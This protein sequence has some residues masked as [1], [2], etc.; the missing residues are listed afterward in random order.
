MPGKVKGLYMWCLKVTSGYKGLEVR[1]L[2]T[3][4]KN[5]LAFCAMLS[6]F[7][8]D[9]IDY[10][11]LNPDEVYKNN[12]LAFT[13]AEREFGIIKMLDPEDMVRME[14]PDRLSVATYLAQYYD[15]FRDKPMLDPPEAPEGYLERIQNKHKTVECEKATV[16]NDLPNFETVYE[17]ETIES[18]NKDSKLLEEDEM[19]KADDEFEALFNDNVKVLTDTDPKNFTDLFEEEIEDIKASKKGAVMQAILSAGIAAVA[20]TAVGDDC[21]KD[22]NESISENLTVLNGSN[23]GDLNANLSKE[24]DFKIGT[25]SLLEQEDDS[26]E[27]DKF[28]TDSGFGT[29][30]GENVN[31][32]YPDYQSEIHHLETEKT[33]EVLNAELNKV[34]IESIEVNVVN[35]NVNEPS[36]T[37]F[38]ERN[39]KLSSRSSSSSSSSESSDSESS[40]SESAP[41]PVDFESMADK[42]VQ[43]VFKDV[44][45]NPELMAEIQK[46]IPALIKEVEISIK[47][48]Q[49]ETQNM[50]PDNQIQTGLIS[51]EN[52][53]FVGQDFNIPDDDTEETH[54]TDSVD[55]IEKYQIALEE[56]EKAESDNESSSSK[57][58]TSSEESRA[59]SGDGSPSLEIEDAVLNEPTDYAIEEELVDGN[60]ANIQKILD[61]TN[62][63]DIP[64]EQGPD[65]GQ[66]S[67]PVAQVEIGVNIRETSDDIDDNHTTTSTSSEDNVNVVTTYDGKSPKHA[68]ESNLHKSSSENSEHE[69]ESTEQVKNDETEIKLTIDLTEHAPEVTGSDSISRRKILS[70]SSSSDSEN[71]ESK[72]SGYPYVDDEGHKHFNSENKSKE[73]DSSKENEAESVAFKFIE[74]RKRSSSSTSSSSNSESSGEDDPNVD[75]NHVTNDVKDLVKDTID[76]PK[77][78]DNETTGRIKISSDSECENVYEIPRADKD[79]EIYDNKDKN[80]A[81][82]STEIYLKDDISKTIASRKISSSSESDSHNS[83]HENVKKEETF[84]KIPDKIMSDSNFNSKH[85][86]HGQADENKYEQSLNDIDP[87]ID[88]DVSSKK[89]I[90]SFASESDIDYTTNLHYK[91]PTLYKLQSLSSAS[92]VEQQE[93]GPTFKAETSSSSSEDEE[94][95]ALPSAGPPE[96][97]KVKIISSDSESDTTDS[98]HEPEEGTGKEVDILIPSCDNETNDKAETTCVTIN[99]IDRIAGAQKEDTIPDISCS[100]QAQEALTSSSPAFSDHQVTLEASGNLAHESASMTLVADKTHEETYS[101]LIL[102]TPYDKETSS[103]SSSDSEDNKISNLKSPIKDETTSRLTNIEDTA[104]SFDPIS[105]EII[106]SQHM[107]LKLNFDIVDDHNRT[108]SKSVDMIIKAS[109]EEQSVK[110][111]SDTSSSSSSTSESESSESDSESK[112]LNSHSRVLDEKEPEYEKLR[113]QGMAGD[114]ANVS[115]EINTKCPEKYSELDEI[116]AP[117]QSATKELKVDI[118]S[119]VDMENTYVSEFSLPSIQTQISPKGHDEVDQ[120]VSKPAVTADIR[121]DWSNKAREISLEEPVK[122]PGPFA[123]VDKDVMKKAAIMSRKMAE[124]VTA[125]LEDQNR[126]ADIEKYKDDEEQMVTPPSTP[127]ESD[128]E[129]ARAKRMAIFKQLQYSTRPTKK[130]IED[131]DEPSESSSGCESP[132]DFKKTMFLWN[133][134]SSTNVKPDQSLIANKSRKISSPFLSGKPVSPT[135]EHMR[136]LH[137][138][139]PKDSTP[140]S[141]ADY[142]RRLSQSS[143]ADENLLTSPVD[144][145]KPAKTYHVKTEP[146]HLTV[147]TKVYPRNQQNLNKTPFTG[148]V[149]LPKSGHI[150]KNE[151]DVKPSSIFA[152]QSISR[153]NSQNQKPPLE[154]IGVRPMS[155]DLKNVTNITSDDSKP[156]N[157]V[158]RRSPRS[159]LKQGKL[160]VEVKPLEAKPLVETG[161]SNDDENCPIDIKRSDSLKDKVKVE[162]IALD[163]RLSQSDEERQEEENKT[164]LKR[165]ESLKTKREDSPRRSL[166]LSSPT[167]PEATIKDGDRVRNIWQSTCTKPPS[168]KIKRKDSFEVKVR[169][170]SLRKSRE[171]KEIEK[172]KRNSTRS[173]SPASRS[174]TPTK[175]LPK[176][177]ITVKPVSAQSSQDEN[178]LE[179]PREPKEIVVVEGKP[180]L[181][182]DDKRVV[183]RRPSNRRSILAVVNQMAG[184]KLKDKDD[185]EAQL[186]SK[187]VNDDQITAIPLNEHKQSASTS[188]EN[189][190]VSDTLSDMSVKKQMSLDSVSPENPVKSSYKH[191][192]EEAIKKCNSIFGLVKSHI[193]ASSKGTNVVPEKVVL[194]SNSVG[195]SERKELNADSKESSE[196]D[197]NSSDSSSSSCKKTKKTGIK[198]SLPTINAEVGRSG[199]VSD[200]D[201]F[202]DNEAVTGS[203]NQSGTS[204]PSLHSSVEI[205][206]TSLKDDLEGIIKD[207]EQ[208]MKSDSEH[209]HQ[210]T[211]MKLINNKKARQSDTTDSDEKQSTEDQKKSKKK[212]RRKNKKKK[213]PESSSSSSSSESSMHSDS[214]RGDDGNTKSKSSDTSSNDAAPDVSKDGSSNHQDMPERKISD[215]SDRSSKSCRPYPV[216]SGVKDDVH[217]I[218]V[219]ETAET[220]KVPKGSTEIMSSQAIEIPQKELIF[221]V[222]DIIP[223]V[224]DKETAY[225]ADQE[226]DSSDDDV[227]DYD[228]DVKLTTK[229]KVKASKSSSESSL[230][231]IEYPSSDNGRYVDS[232]APKDSHDAHVAHED[233]EDE[234]PITYKPEDEDFEANHEPAEIVVCVP[235]PVIHPEPASGRSRT[236]SS[237]SNHSD[238]MGCFEIPPSDI[239]F[240]DDNTLEASSSDK[241]ESPVGIHFS[242]EPLWSRN[243]DNQESS[244]DSESETH[245]EKSITLHENEL[246]VNEEK[247]LSV[248]ERASSSGTEN[249]DDDDDYVCVKSQPKENNEHSFSN[250]ITETV[251][252]CLV[253]NMHP[254]NELK[255]ADMRISDDNN[256]NQDMEYDYI[257]VKDT[258]YVN[259]DVEDTE[260]DNVDIQDTE[261]DNVDVKDTEDDNI[262]SQYSEEDELLKSVIEDSH[263]FKAPLLETFIKTSF[264]EDMDSDKTDTD[265]VLEDETNAEA[266]VIRE[267]ES[268]IHHGKGRTSSVSSS[269]SSSSDSSKGDNKTG[270]SGTTDSEDDLYSDS[271]RDVSCDSKMYILPECTMITCEDV[272]QKDLDIMFK[273]LDYANQLNSKMHPV[274]VDIFVHPGTPDVSVYYNVSPDHNEGEIDD[275]NDIYETI[276][277]HLEE[278]DFN[279]GEITLEGIELKPIVGQELE[280]PSVPE[281]PIESDD[282]LLQNII[283]ENEMNLKNIVRRKSSTSSSSSE[284]SSHEDMPS[285]TSPVDIGKDIPDV[286]IPVEQLQRSRNITESSSS[287][288]SKSDKEFKDALEIQDDMNPDNVYDDIALVTDVYVRKPLHLYENVIL[289]DRDDS[290]IPSLVLE[291]EVHKSITELSGKLDDISTARKLS[292]SSLSS[293][294]GSDLKSSETVIEPIKAI[295]ASRKSRKA[296]S[297]MTSQSSSTSSNDEAES[298]KSKEQKQQKKMRK[299]KRRKSS[300]IDNS[301]QDDKIKPSGSAD[302]REQPEQKF[303]TFER[304]GGRPMAEEQKSRSGSASSSSSSCET[305][306]DNNHEDGNMDKGFLIGREKDPSKSEVARLIQQSLELDRRR[307]E[308]K[309]QEHERLQAL[310]DGFM[311]PRDEVLEHEH[312]QKLHSTG[313]VSSKEDNNVDLDASSQEEEEMEEAEE[314]EGKQEEEEMEH[315]EEIS[316]ELQAGEATP[317]SMPSGVDSEP[318]PDSSPEEATG[319]AVVDVFDLQDSSPDSGP[320]MEPQ[321]LFVKLKEAQLRNSVLEAE[322]TKL[323]GRLLLLENTESQRRQ[324]ERRSDDMAARLREVEKALNSAR[325]EIN[326]YQDLM[327]GSQGQYIA[328][329]KKMQGDLT[330][331]EKKYHKAKKLIKEYQ[332][333]EKDFLA[334]REALI[335]QQ[336]E[337]NQQYDALVKSLKDRIFQLESELREAQQAAGLPVLLPHRQ[338]VTVVTETSPPVRSLPPPVRDSGMRPVQDKDSISSESEMSSLSEPP[339]PAV[340][341]TVTV[342]PAS[343][344]NSMP[345]TKLLDTSVSKA[346]AQ[347][348]ANSPRRP[349]T[350]QRSKSQDSEEL[351]EAAIQSKAESGLETW[352]K[353]DRTAEYILNLNSDNTVKKSDPSL[354]IS[355][356]APSD[357]APTSI[358]S[359]QDAFSAGYDNVQAPPTSNTVPAPPPPPVEPTDPNG[360]SDDWDT[361][362]DRLNS[363]SESS[364]T[365]SQR[366]Y[367]P[368]QP[369]FRNKNSEIPGLDSVSTDTSGTVE[370]TGS[371]SSAKKSKGLLPKLPFKF[372]SSDRDKG[373]G[374]TLIS[375]RGINSDDVPSSEGGIT[376]ISKRKLDTGLD[377]DASAPRPKIGASI[378]SDSSSGYMVGETESARSYQFSGIPGN[379]D[380]VSQSGGLNQFGAGQINDWTVENVKHWLIGIEMERFTEIFTERGINGAQLATLDANKLKAMGVTSA[381]DRDYLKKRLKELRTVLEKEK[382]QQEKERKQMEKMAKTRE[383]EQK[384]QSK[385]K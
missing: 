56:K 70:S 18:S 114:L 82:V 213:T 197:R 26:V 65:D 238:L 385:K 250:N 295:K 231:E 179:S 264:E 350:K 214:D 89:N 363:G 210:E 311:V 304:I 270:K 308:L 31:E 110:L 10:Y 47:A 372:G 9:L 149:S 109:N 42:I 280:Q 148:S 77:N 323:K 189:S 275:F 73:N 19:S 351:I 262:E 334:E 252:D 327:E 344:F 7:R 165:K 368:S 383:K 55:L 217:F 249:D 17:R 369:N 271:K 69:N 215:S 123:N 152:G 233:F 268:A 384:K 318:S 340:E 5:G 263:P 296:S 298:T 63:V 265:D 153:R 235:F 245:S 290:R 1:N 272:T 29:F 195:G 247:K 341:D 376:L 136:K 177:N 100:L 37:G 40:D 251:G 163:K 206:K 113:H 129:K 201:T 377:F 321:A 342:D 54:L 228:K 269:S 4:W 12:D 46:D 180:P 345:P 319:K 241:Q 86:E 75:E 35:E 273:D 48:E 91:T 94:A 365:I 293:D 286:S 170:A 44:Q 126:E 38:T 98:S 194:S 105:S 253:P 99:L 243:E 3:C 347:L 50:V 104:V 315:T 167:T 23:Y 13:I 184:S 97:I 34:K 277:P 359:D 150:K 301:V 343:M 87:L 95:P 299:G 274:G 121:I 187:K 314:E 317:L 255:G 353:H 85:F 160:N 244:S 292:L 237:S 325:K 67:L 196:S 24:N 374:I 282:E 205:H 211:S 208:D 14:A 260:G 248:C 21:N 45:F 191:E 6:R 90:S 232:V 199:H 134:K 93:K 239:N 348:A 151:A 381:K 78:M 157:N 276:D 173:A 137:S 310:H 161:K 371:E 144:E 22:Y 200:H 135:G 312:L 107:N 20:A 76:S 382:K 303:D 139:L 226:S 300:S 49:N 138:S 115:D 287:S 337:K 88:Y 171:E 373:G 261:Y 278:V 182:K 102:L 324:E 284:K 132:T 119:N 203:T 227:A 66:Q 219:P 79:T 57:S 116:L 71:D 68:L 230:S 302:E 258:N 375:A 186:T 339:T 60:T 279:K 175:D 25:K 103:S 169:S 305:D 174:S 328:L 181:P 141:V 72:I 159:V 332:Q 51:L 8:P 257:D 122:Q 289:F 58:S 92:S 256:D 336:N 80:N 192:Q 64:S 309:R 30:C 297:A 33:V 140:G 142:I 224:T 83:G 2:T 267:L 316:E 378:N 288:S 84:E 96:L 285:T 172:E 41:R 331:L 130:K 218:I 127:S 216:D 349:P 106:D 333:R 366:S 36:V 234:V 221:S 146:I 101:S 128:K 112:Y 16:S 355:K 380:S 185:V 59:K 61:G 358:S 357:H 361:P 155:I 254:F 362:R 154:K 240:T 39:E 242:V 322:L 81:F 246:N 204:F 131:I 158:V 183:E 291:D 162:V 330:A 202:K 329:E 236:S 352:S 176:V 124:S 143:S 360:L 27:I 212:K 28:R 145:I 306:S 15:Y 338:E 220:V 346:K 222:A 320:E 259:V 188:T 133:R 356:P 62:L 11:S 164:E 168:P 307:E 111:K 108:E 281:I 370:T 118:I 198:R 193:K 294:S 283:L 156:T 209:F 266:V 190:C 53:K 229:G 120:I 207:L 43:S 367:D 125:K 225:L 313:S 74:E 326:H 117:L 223:Q 364:S 166:L 335:Q 32:N 379:E 52:N 147:E 354:D 178:A